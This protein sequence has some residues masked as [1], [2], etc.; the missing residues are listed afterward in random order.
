MNVFSYSVA[1]QGTL[2]AEQDDPSGQDLTVDQFAQPRVSGF[3]TTK[4]KA[5]ELGKY[6]LNEELI[7]EFGDQ[8]P[9]YEFVTREVGKDANMIDLVSEA[10]SDGKSLGAVVIRKHE[11][12]K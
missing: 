10:I 7:Y 6:T 11:V 2:E 9:T 8:I 4:S 12:A 3:A 5:L 1:T